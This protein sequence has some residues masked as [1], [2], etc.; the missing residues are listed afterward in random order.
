MRRLLLESRWPGGLVRATAF[1]AVAIVLFLSQQAWPVDGII[2]DPAD[3]LSDAPWDEIWQEHPGTADRIVLWTGQ[4]SFRDFT[5]DYR[6]RSMFSSNTSYEYGTDSTYDPP[7]APYRRLSFP[8]NSFWHGLQF[9][10]ERPTWGVH[11]EW[12]MPQQGIQESITQCDWRIPDWPFTNM[13][14]MTERWLQGQRVDFSFDFQLFQHI[15]AAPVEV[16]P[17]FGFRWER[18]DVKGYDQQIVKYDDFWLNPPWTIAGEILRFHQEYSMAYLGG[19]M[20]TKLEC[21]ALPPTLITFQGDWGYTSGSNMDHHELFIE[22]DSR[23][24]MTTWGAAWHVSLTFETLLSSRCSIGCQLDHLD[25]CTRGRV[26]L[27]NGIKE[28]EETSYN[29]VKADSHQTSIMAFIRL[30]I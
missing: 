2:I 15:F 24:Y 6:F 20:R 16:W 9:G 3:V 14:Y 25:I 4:P 18:F 10:V 8:L 7:Y 28:T 22:G 26:R 12:M 27:V 11:C 23:S 29:G 21:A 13:S 19:Q 5:I 1:W 30:R 17:M